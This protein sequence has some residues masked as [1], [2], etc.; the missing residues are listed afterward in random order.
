MTDN[1]KTKS[2]LIADDVRAL[3]RARTPLIWIVTR[4]E[5][6]VERYLVEAAAAAGY[7]PRAWDCGQGVTDAISGKPL[8][9]GTPDP[10]GMFAYIIERATAIGQGERVA[11][12]MR[13]LPAWIT[14]PAFIREL[15]TL[16]NAVRVLPTAV[17]DKAQAIIILATTGDVPPELQALA[18]VIQWPLPDRGEI[19][20]IL[21]A[22][23]EALPDE[24]KEGAAPNGRRD[25]AIDAAVGLS[26]EEAA[27]TYAKSLV[28]FRRIDP[29]AVTGEKKSIIAKTKTL[30]WFDPLPG[31]LDAVGGLVPLKG[32]LTKRKLAFT[33][34]ARAY[35]LPRP[36]G[37]LFVG[38][39]GCGKSYTAKATA[40]AWGVPLIRLDLGALKGKF[41]GQSEGNL[42]EA[43]GIIDAL[44]PCVVWL[45][46]L[47]KSLA[48]ATQGAADGGVSA[49]ALGA[50]LS[51]MQERKGEA[52]I[53]ATSNDVS[54]L[55]P[56]LLRKGRFDEIWFVD[57]PTASEIAEIVKAT[58]KTHDRDGLPIDV[59]KV[60]KACEGFTGAEIAAI[61]PAAMFE[62]FADGGREI[63]TA[64]LVQA[65]GTVVPLTKTAAEKIASLRAWAA[66]RA[67]PASAPEAEKPA[68]AR[69]RAIDL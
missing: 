59:A 8:Q 38:V 17:K 24:L 41:V 50:I 16:R 36:N 19:T 20:A 64:D 28:Q 37:A 47:E 11:W 65:A 58:L 68:K 42:R 56:E 31:G 69:G 61:V 30:E 4:E 33:P 52:F 67:R 9:V 40:T 14:G 6:R 46:E 3:L 43:I 12:I 21:D 22:A 27:S 15:R 48:G 55:P 54:A 5:Q 25:A 66:G 60:T 45:D 26:G 29:A 32:W 23:I 7:I 44:G 35:G 63:T 57:T 62:A 10:L 34:A 49:D 51:W 53:V 1:V 39:S 13:D 18:T 2:Q